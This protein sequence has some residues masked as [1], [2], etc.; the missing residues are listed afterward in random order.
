MLPIISI[1]WRPNV[2]KSTLFNR[3]IWE[4]VAI[5]SPIAWTTRDRIIWHVNEKWLIPYTIIDTW[6]IDLGKWIIEENILTQA[7]VAADWSDL[8]LYIIDSRSE[9]TLE[10]L[11][12]ANF[13]KKS[14]K[15][16]NIILISSKADN[17][18][19]EITKEIFKLWFWEPIFI[20]SVH[21]VWISDLKD[22]I[23]K[24]LRKL[25]YKK[26]EIWKLD[27]QIHA[28]ICIVWRPN[29]GKSSLINSFLWEERL[30]VSEIAWTT[31]D[32]TDSLLEHDW[33][34][35]NLIDTAWIRKKWKI[36]V[37][38]EKYSYLRSLI[39]IER[40]DIVLLILDS[41]WRITSVDQAIA[42]MALENNKWLILVCN[43][44]DLKEKWEEE[45][46]L[47]ILYLRR[48]FPFL[49]WAP[50]I[51]LSAKTKK[52][53]QKLFPMIDIIMTQRNLRIS[54]WTLNN[55]IER[56][57]K[58]HKPSWTKNVHP[59]IYYATQVWVNPP[60]IMLYV[61]KE[62]YFHFSYFR[63]L[64]NKLREQFWF[65]WTAIKIEA[66]EKKPRIK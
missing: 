21:N 19:R 22:S 20:S 17:S 3:L 42:G 5:T 11:K 63:Y 10:D 36:E 25:W 37:W 31:R 39:A 50:Y 35:Y 47:F 8:I 16:Q 46:N 54:T 58:A 4:R 29:A 57:T 64:E 52:H 38:I 2:W 55:F 62:E 14:C 41:G 59:K 18:S 12:A 61:N 45:K 26:T 13:V 51:M 6:W 27:K 44:W 28:N 53:M 65:D 32:S 60:H 49:P 9:I 23:N 30:I 15:C 43:K 56:M 24:H 33:K 48:K 40:A 7:K 66:V 34:Y 1:I